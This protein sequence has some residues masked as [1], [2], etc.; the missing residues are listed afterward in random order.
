MITTKTTTIT[1]ASADDQMKPD[2]MTDRMAKLAQMEADGKTDLS[3][4]TIV[5][6]VCTTRYWRDQSAAEEFASFITGIAE[7]YNC[8]INS[9]VFGDGTWPGA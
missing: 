8:G 2:L 5:S 7:I 1:W 3:Y 6:P 9:I 4:Y